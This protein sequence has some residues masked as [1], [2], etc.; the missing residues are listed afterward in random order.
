MAST[1][2]TPELLA[3]MDRRAAAEVR[4]RPIDAETDGLVKPHVGC[5]GLVGQQAQLPQPG[6]PRLRFGVIQQMME[7]DPNEED[8]IED[9]RNRAQ[10]T[11]PSSLASHDGPRALWRIAS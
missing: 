1:L 7:R 8:R 2:A 9:F 11:V 4:L 3:H 5:E 10:G 6:A